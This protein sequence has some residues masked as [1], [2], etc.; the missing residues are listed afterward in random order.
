MKLPPLAF[1]AVIVRLL[2]LIALTTSSCVN[3]SG[4]G[5]GV[6]TPARWGGSSSSPPV[7]VGGP[8]MR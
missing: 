6:G 7:F 1:R 4:V 3:E 5:V 2:M 8:S